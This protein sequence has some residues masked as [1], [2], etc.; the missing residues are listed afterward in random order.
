MVNGEEGFVG[1]TSIA[2]GL[3]RRARRDQ[4]EQFIR[5]PVFVGEKIQELFDG[6]T[7]NDTRRIIQVGFFAIRSENDR[8]NRAGASC[9]LIGSKFDNEACVVA[10]G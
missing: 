5:T 1:V 2:D 7:E 10:S 9:E 3:A 8:R 6:R 4:A